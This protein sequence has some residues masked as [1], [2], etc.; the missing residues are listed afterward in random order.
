MIGGL[1][2]WG[3]VKLGWIPWEG[4]MGANPIQ[5]SWKVLLPG[6]CGLAIV[7]GTPIALMNLGTALT[8]SVVIATQLLLGLL[9]D[10]FINGKPLSWPLVAG[11]VLM[12]AG[13]MLILNATD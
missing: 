12:F 11:A 3:G 8:F 13:C 7:I 10:V 6:L 9:I 5:L 2:L 4:N 1:A